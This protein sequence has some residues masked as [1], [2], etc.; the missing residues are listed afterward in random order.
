MKLDKTPPPKAEVRVVKTDGR[1]EYDVYLVTAT[2]LG[3]AKKVGTSRIATDGGTTVPNLRA[4]ALE[5]LAT[6]GE[7]ELVE[8]LTASGRLSAGVA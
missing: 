7:E 3:G 1:L 2:R 6:A 4:A 8:I 5:Y